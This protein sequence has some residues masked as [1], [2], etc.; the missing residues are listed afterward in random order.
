MAK[1]VINK[2]FIIFAII[3]GLATILNF[4]L[5]ML[6]V[7]ILN[8]NYILA[9]VISYVICVIISYFVNSLFSFN[10]SINNIVVELK[11]LIQY[12]VMKMIILF[13]DS[14][15]LYILVDLI[16]VNLYISKIILTLFFTLLSFFASKKIITAGDEINE[17]KCL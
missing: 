1:Y 16:G 14:L 13:F 11:K 7:E 8:F 15:F 5:L 9:N 2:Q 6:F 12:F 10:H 17:N 4:L 3:G